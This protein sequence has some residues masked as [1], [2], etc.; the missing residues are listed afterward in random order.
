MLAALSSALSFDVFL[1]APYYQLAI[2]DRNDIETAV[3]LLAIGVAVSEIAGWGRRQFTESSRRAGYLSGVAHAARLAADG[4]S[5]KD[6]ANT[7]AC[8]IGEV[9]ELDDCRFEPGT[10]ESSSAPEGRPVLHRDG[11][12]SCAGHTVDACGHSRRTAHREAGSPAPRP[13]I[14]VKDRRRGRSPAE[15]V[16]AGRSAEAPVPT[17]HEAPPDALWAATM[18]S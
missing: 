1:T 11:T 12:L 14:D 16:L 17:G 7:I 18:R 3:L 10:I 6:L 15:V 4:A 13:W 9:L 8:M 5:T 2:F